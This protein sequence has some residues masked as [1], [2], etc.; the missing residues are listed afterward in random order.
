MYYY[1][2]FY[3]IP[4]ESYTGFLSFIKHFLEG[5]R[6]KLYNIYFYNDLVYYLFACVD[7]ETRRRYTV[8]CLCKCI[9]ITLQSMNKIPQ[10]LKRYFAGPTRI[11]LLKCRQV[12]FTP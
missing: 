1:A 10:L 8:F 2:L 6:R 4:F 7:N 11:D 3:N 12:R 5:K 9:M